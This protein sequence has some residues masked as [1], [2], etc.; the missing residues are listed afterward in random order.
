MRRVFAAALAL[1]VVLTSA[2]W[3]DSQCAGMGE[4][5]A[6]VVL[7]GHADDSSLHDAHLP[8]GDD[9]SEDAGHHGEH[10]SGHGHHSAPGDAGCAMMAHCSVAVVS[11]VAAVVISELAVLHDVPGPTSDQPLELALQPEAP[12]PKA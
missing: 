2:G 9:T 4:A 10:C 3:A 5:S 8:A 11:T 7:A 12:P 1:S 6:T